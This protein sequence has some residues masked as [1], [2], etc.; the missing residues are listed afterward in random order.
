[1]AR[2]GRPACQRAIFVCL[3]RERAS[4]DGL[5]NILGQSGRRTLIAARQENGQVSICLQIPSL[6]HGA[7]NLFLPIRGQI[8]FSPAVNVGNRDP[9]EGVLRLTTVKHPSGHGR[10]R[11][12]DGDRS[13]A[14]DRGFGWST[15]L[16]LAKN[17]SDKHRGEDRRRDD[18]PQDAMPTSR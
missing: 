14:S 13:R 15:G 6:P 7:A 9:R 11:F 8:I 10:Y 1:M 2:H 17:Q 5:G 16:P 3:K 4:T 18:C 12:S